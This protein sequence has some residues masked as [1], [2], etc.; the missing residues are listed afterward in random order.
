MF[1]NTEIWLLHPDNSLADPVAFPLP[2]RLP[3]PEEVFDE[4]EVDEDGVEWVEL[5]SQK[6]TSSVMCQYPVYSHRK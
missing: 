4:D 6:P 2:D 1:N 3:A 5:P